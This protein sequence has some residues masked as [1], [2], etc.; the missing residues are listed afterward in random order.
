MTCDRA[1]KEEAETHSALAETHEGK[2]ML[3]LV[4]D[5][6]SVLE[7]LENA[8]ADAG[9][10]VVTACNGAQAIAELDAN[11]IRFDAVITDINLGAGPDG[12]EISQHVRSLVPDM[13]IVYLTGASAHEWPSQ[14][15][16]GSV[17]A[18]KPFSL[19]QFT[20]TV[21]GLLTE[22]VVRR[23]LKK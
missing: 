14:G 1:L 9:F 8:L 17:L 10:D 2:K 11:P 4:E 13:P 16:G 5:E 20:T 3:L 18:T 19:A 15:V 6:L 22:A 12:W 7:V 21:S 23:A